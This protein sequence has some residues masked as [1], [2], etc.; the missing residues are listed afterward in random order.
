MAH[1][2]NLLGM[3]D[4]MEGHLDSAQSYFERALAIYREQGNRDNESA[5]LNNLGEIQRI[6]GDLEG[7][8][9][10]HLENLGLSRDIG[11]RGMEI[12]LLVNIDEVR[13]RL[14]E[15]GPAEADLRQVLS[16]LGDEKWLYRGPAFSHLAVASS[17][18]GRLEEATAAARQGLAIAGESGSPEDLCLAWQAL[19][20]TA[21]RLRDR[22]IESSDGA[23][24]T[25]SEC[26]AESL[27]I[28]MEAGI[29]GQRADTLREWAAFELSLGDGDRAKSLGRE[30]LELYAKMGADKWVE[31]MDK[32]YG[33]MS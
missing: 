33:T 19:G 31:R 16:S 21:A 5:V 29:D 14:G 18:L 25:A 26:F 22:M 3:I 1:A 7:A 6:R 32:A 27:R 10:R 11:N 23:S 20:I 2:L 8:L 12:F 4:T 13:L 28:A 17:R 15:D 30:A 9:A 24:I